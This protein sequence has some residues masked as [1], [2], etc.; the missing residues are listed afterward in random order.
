MP[1]IFISYSRRDGE[2][3]KRLNNTLQAQGNDVWIDWEDIPKASDWLNEIYAGIDSSDAFIVVVSEHS[4]KSEIC[5]YEIAH[6]LR[7]SKRI[8]PLIRQPIISEKETELEGVWRNTSWESMARENWQAIRHLNWIMV[9]NDENFDTD[10]NTLVKT[11]AEDIAHRKEHTR[12]F[13]RAIT[14]DRQ[15]QNPSFLLIGDE[16]V[17]AEQ[18][19]T[20]GAEKQP[21]TDELHIAYVT[22]SRRSENER[23]ARLNQLTQRTRQFQ[24]AAFASGIVGVLAIIAT[25][26]AF[27]SSMRASQQRDEAETQ[28]AFAQ[29]NLRVVGETLTPVQPT[30]DAAN[31]QIAKARDD[32]FIAG[33]TLTPVQ[34]TLDAANAQVLRAALDIIEAREVVSTSEAEVTAANL[35]VLQAGEQVR[36]IGETL[37]PVQPTLD[38]AR[39]Q[40][41]L[42]E[43]QLGAAQTQSYRAA[44]QISSAYETLT[45]IPATLTAV[46]QV[47]QDSQNVNES[48]LLASLARTEHENFR[49]ELAVL[50]SVR[51]LKTAYTTEADSIF[52]RALEQIYTIYRTEPSDGNI[53]YAVVLSPDNQTLFIADTS[54]SVYGLNVATN[55]ET[56][57]FG[58]PSDVR[59]I[60][61]SPDGNFLITAT[62]TTLHGWNLTTQAQEWQRDLPERPSALATS[63]SNDRFAIGFES[64]LVATHDMTGARIAENAR[65][66]ARINDLAFTP[67]SQYVVSASS[68]ETARIWIVNTMRQ[69]SGFQAPD[70]ALSVVFHP[71]GNLV[72][73]GTPSGVLVY[74]IFRNTLAQRYIDHINVISVN[75]NA[76]GTLL[77]TS[78]TDSTIRLWDTETQLIAAYVEGHTFG[79]AKARFS[80]DFERIIAYEAFEARIHDINANENLFIEYE[81]EGELIA[82][83]VTGDDVIVLGGESTLWIDDPEN[84]RL[85]VINLP[86]IQGQR[87]ALTVAQDGEHA[88]VSTDTDVWLVKLSSRRVRLLGGRDRRFSAINGFTANGNT[89]YYGSPTALRYL[90]TDDGTVI[91]EY[92]FSTEAERLTFSPDGAYVYAITGGELTRIEAQTGIVIATQTMTNGAFYY[93][94]NVS[95]DGRM[96]AVADDENVVTV[97]S[98][99]LSQVLWSLPHSEVVTELRFTPDSKTLL[100]HRFGTRMFVWRLSDGMLTRR[101]QL[102]DGT[103]YALEPLFGA[104]EWVVLSSENSLSRW[105]VDY[106]R[107]LVRA[108]QAVFRDFSDEERRLFGIIDE[109]A[110]CQVN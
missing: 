55:Q 86:M 33:Q 7:V 58:H 42:S 88:L 46:A 95:P 75:Y 67:N 25:L 11:L 20:E 56:V 89:A 90:N 34:P 73:V 13:V 17:S 14:W 54:Q 110:T 93:G 71:F 31:A 76:D 36:L 83:S 41:D 2:F 87:Y 104:P 38:A 9:D 68:D 61:I 98:G 99:D 45:P 43:R 97:Y 102:L 100:T 28:Y 48:L 60:A 52:S 65:H 26:V 105:D 47:I 35:L 18:W 30:L 91:A 10:Y 94:L 59:L 96:V 108:C 12:Y 21:P 40:I 66:E 82:L 72:A 74:D 19:L 101:I 63:P 77:L 50:L 57:R 15:A 8:I 53:F 3:A 109:V 32:I 79:M 84:P 51:A 44:T 37:T 27:S 70:G 1:D 16:L 92:P 49:S 22:A 24:R 103:V 106:Q 62:D 81:V 85:S 23:V 69:L 4:L 107:A 6:A 64:G 78:S 29:E 39:R 5:N 80:T